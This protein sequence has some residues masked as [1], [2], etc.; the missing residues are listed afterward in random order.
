MLEH[1]DPDTS[2]AMVAISTEEEMDAA[3]AALLSLGEVRDNTLDG[4]DNAELM[5]IGGQNVAVDAAP[6]PIRLDQVSIDKAIAGL[7]QDDQNRDTTTNDKQERENENPPAP[8]KVGNPNGQKPRP[9]TKKNDEPDST[10]KGTLKTKMYALKKKVETKKRSFKCSECDVVKKMI[11]E[12]NI[13]H[14]ECHNP[15]IC[16]VCGKLFKLTSSLA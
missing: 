9:S 15:Q 4:D 6:E 12:L 11:K 7:I 8:S 2:Q 3:A 5:P 16:G 1:E 10:A 14:E 13:H